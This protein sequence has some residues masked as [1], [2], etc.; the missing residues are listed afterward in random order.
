M[1]LEINCPSSGNVGQSGD[2]WDKVLCMSRDKGHK[3]WSR[4]KGKKPADPLAVCM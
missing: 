4:I 2:T 1:V 3:G